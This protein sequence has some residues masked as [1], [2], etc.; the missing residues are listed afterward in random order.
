MNM[1][2]IGYPE[3]S[4]TKYQCTL[5]NMPEER[6]SHRKDLLCTVC[7]SALAPARGNGPSGPAILFEPQTRLVKRRGEGG[8][9][10]G[11]QDE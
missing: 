7:W 2:R 1:G 10:G 11:S 5:R 4:V 9:G 3:T 8:V 6:R